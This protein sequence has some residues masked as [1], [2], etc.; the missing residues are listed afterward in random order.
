MHAIY[1]VKSSFPIFKSL[2]LAH[3]LH[4]WFVLHAGKNEEQY[5]HGINQIQFIC[6]LFSKSFFCVCF[7]RFFL[8]RLYLTLKRIFNFLP[9]MREDY[10]LEV[11]SVSMT[12][13]IY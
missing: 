8:C 5:I 2:Y 4:S 9:T 7:I 10:F 1:S 11:A 3:S 13:I 12:Q 6:D